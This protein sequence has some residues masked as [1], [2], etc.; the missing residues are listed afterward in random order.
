MTV[1]H[2]SVIGVRLKESY[3]IF[4]RTNHSNWWELTLLGRSLSLGKEN[5]HIIIMVDH[6]TKYVEAKA[7]KD[8]KA[9][10]FADFFIQQGILRH[11]AI[12][13]C[14][15]DRAQSFCSNFTRELLN[16]LSTKHVLTSSYHPETNG[17]AERQCK[18]ITDM[19]A[20]YCRGDQRDWDLFLPYLIFAYNTARQDST[21][22][23]PF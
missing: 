7:V 5:Q 20:L 21:Q 14:I 9:K 12:K 11:G 10:T 18:T 8:T 3:R 23:S 4:S 17:L 19:L 13:K 6:F 1:N 16:S 2:E 15:T 22:Y